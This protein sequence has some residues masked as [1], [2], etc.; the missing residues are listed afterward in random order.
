M[1][2]AE[3]LKESLA[4]EGIHREPTQDEI[5]ATMDFVSTQVITLDD[6][7]RLQAV[8]A[9]GKPL[10]LNA[11]LNVQVGSHAAPRGGRKIGERLSH[12]IYAAMEGKDPWRVHCD[13][14][15]LHPFMDGNGRTGRALWLWQMCRNGSD[16]FAI[17]FLHRFYYQALSHAR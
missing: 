4:I 3:F 1:G 16:P 14:E 15:L 2:F 17:S 10:R 8:Y 6:V 7:C 9:P 5:D 13:F 12:I 11:R